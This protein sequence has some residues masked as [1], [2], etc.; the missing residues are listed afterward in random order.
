MKGSYDYKEIGHYYSKAVSK[1]SLKVFIQTI[2][3]MYTK[4]M[5]VLKNLKM[6]QQDKVVSGVNVVG[7]TEKNSLYP[8]CPHSPFLAPPTFS[9]GCLF[10]P[11][12]LLYCL[13]L[14]LFPSLPLPFPFSVSSA[15]PPL[16]SLRSSPP[17][18]SL[19]PLPPRL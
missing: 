2:V 3:S 5:D 13:P 1:F 17:F 10:H 15:F 6:F 9:S 7:K 11:Y 19:S 14:S 18:P 16:P 12:L 4:S 8:S